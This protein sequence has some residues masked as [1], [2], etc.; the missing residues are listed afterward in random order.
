MPQPSMDLRY[1]YWNVYRNCPYTQ[2]LRRNLCQY[3]MSSPL[4]I[5]FGRLEMNFVPDFYLFSGFYKY[6]PCCD[7]FCLE[8]GMQ[9][10]FYLRKVF[11]NK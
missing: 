4:V 2:L 3:F 1:W 7:Q 9:I 6:K 11:R 8:T 5:V 10:K